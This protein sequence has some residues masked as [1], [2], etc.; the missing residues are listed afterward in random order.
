MEVGLRHILA[1]EHVRHEPEQ[2]RYAAREAETDGKIMDA[3]HIATLALEA[4]GM[5][6]HLSET[7]HG[8][9]GNGEFR[10]D[11]DGGHGAELVVHGH[12]VKEEIGEAHEVLSPGKQDAE[13]GGSQ[14][15]PFEGPLHNEETEQK[16]REYKGTHIYRPA[17]AGLLAPVLGESTIDGRKHAVGLLHGFRTGREGHAGP[18]LCVGHKQCPRLAYS[19][20]PGG[21]VATLQAATGLVGRILGLLGEFALSAHA[22][23]AV[24]PGVVEVAQIDAHTQQTS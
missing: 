15:R 10:N 16:E 4:L 21:D 7:E 8:Q 24:L 14:K 20:A 19:I 6:H 13:D 22:L 23:L 12:V 17:G 18:S 3:G 5:L 11:Q 1:E 2:Q 9:Q